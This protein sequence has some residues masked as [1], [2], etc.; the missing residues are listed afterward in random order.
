MLT[1]RISWNKCFSHLTILNINHVNNIEYKLILRG[2]DVFQCSNSNSEFR[3]WLS[4]GYNIQWG[5]SQNPCVSES[6]VFISMKTSRQTNQPLHNDT[7]AICTTQINHLMAYIHV[8]RTARCA[9][10][11]VKVT[12]YE[13]NVNFFNFMACGT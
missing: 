10:N 2:R 7:L 11:R 5:K 1:C 13:M 9:Q 12:F 4:G 8:V 3:E 6:T